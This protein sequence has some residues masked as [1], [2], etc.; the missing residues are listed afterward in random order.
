MTDCLLSERVKIQ[1]KHCISVTAWLELFHRFFESL[2]LLG[3]R[4]SFTTQ[5]ESRFNHVKHVQVPDFDAWQ[6]WANDCIIALKKEKKINYWVVVW[7]SKR[8]IIWEGELIGLPGCW[9]VCSN[10][11]GWTLSHSTQRGNAESWISWC[12]N[13]LFFDSS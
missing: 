7:M 5:S 13:K 4:G 12:T 9:T 8:G 10:E 11:A 2:D 6:E 1:W 3:I